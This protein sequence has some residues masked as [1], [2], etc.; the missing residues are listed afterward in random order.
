[1]CLREGESKF[2]TSIILETQQQHTSYGEPESHKLFFIPNTIASM[3]R[4]KVL[5]TGQVVDMRS[6]ELQKPLDRLIIRI[7]RIISI[8]QVIR[9]NYNTTKVELQEPVT[10]TIIVIRIL[11]TSSN[12]QAD[13]K[14]QSHHP[15]AAL[16]ARNHKSISSSSSSTEVAGK[17]AEIIYCQWGTPQFPKAKYFVKDHHSFPAEYLQNFQIRGSKK[18]SQ[19]RS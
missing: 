17:S 15:A 2:V 16:R 14:N 9:R 6:I 3:K 5:P 19:S 7:I 18:I 10:Q 11:L 13:T 8:F 4:F 12:E 1:M